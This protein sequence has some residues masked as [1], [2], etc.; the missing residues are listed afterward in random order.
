MSRYE[1]VTWLSLA[2]TAVN[3]AWEFVHSRS[4]DAFLRPYKADYATA[5]R[6]SYHQALAAF[7]A[8]YV[9]S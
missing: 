1:A 8:A 2:M 6:L 7:A 9:L 4:T 3:F 5:F